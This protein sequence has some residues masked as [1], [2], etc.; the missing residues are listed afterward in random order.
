M[1][2]MLWLILSFSHAFSSEGL[3]LVSQGNDNHHIT[4]THFLFLFFN[5]WILVQRSCV[6]HIATLISDKSCIHTMDSSL[7]W[8]ILTVKDYSFENYPWNVIAHNLI[9]TV[10][11]FSLVWMPQG[12]SNLWYISLW[13]E[14]RKLSLGEIGFSMTLIIRVNNIRSF[15]KRK[16]KKLIV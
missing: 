11:M 9:N 13:M 15:G 16:V 12:E 7:Q 6:G 1:L 4:Q 14:R 8:N 10:F 3:W 5:W 2:I